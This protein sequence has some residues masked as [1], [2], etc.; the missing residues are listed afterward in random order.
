[1]YNNL[2][3]SLQLSNKSKKTVNCAKNIV[4]TQTQYTLD[5]VVLHITKI[6][7]HLPSHM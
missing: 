4:E 3:F 6:I 7:Y 1:M 5:I 2:L